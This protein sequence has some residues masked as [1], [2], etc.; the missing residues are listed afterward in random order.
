MQKARGQFPGAGAIG[1][2]DCC[3]ADNVPVICPT[4]Q[5]FLKAAFGASPEPIGHLRI[6]LIDIA[7]PR[8]L[9]GIFP[10]VISLRHPR[11]L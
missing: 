3:E 2:V 5:I 4:C 11:N 7:K 8:M 9:R 6:C 10:P 1:A